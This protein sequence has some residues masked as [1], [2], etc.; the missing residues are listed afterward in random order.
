MQLPDGGGGECSADYMGGD[1][2]EGVA[3]MCLCVPR[4]LR[5]CLQRTVGCRCGGWPLL[6][7]GAVAISEGLRR[8]SGRGGGW[9]GDGR[10]GLVRAGS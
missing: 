3:K 4:T 1:P 5:R 6:A 8:C 7:L 9:S 2:L 10:S